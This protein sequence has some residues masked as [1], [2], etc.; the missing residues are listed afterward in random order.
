MNL[1]QEIKETTD[2]LESLKR[3]QN[4]HTHKWDNEEGKF[5]PEN[6][7]KSE[8]IIGDFSRCHGSDYFPAMRSVPYQKDR[9]TRTCEI[10]GLEQ[11]SY[12]QEAK[13]VVTGAKF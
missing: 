13:K 7:T 5:N 3:K 6:T 4:N 12:E 8:L 10:C 2:R 1:Q 9:W 11:H